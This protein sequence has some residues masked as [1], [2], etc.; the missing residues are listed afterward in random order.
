[1][2]TPKGPE[3][4]LRAVSN[5]DLI[6]NLTNQFHRPISKAS[7]SPPHKGELSRKLEERES[8]VSQLQR[9]KNSLS[10][11]VEELKKQLDEENK[12]SSPSPHLQIWQLPLQKFTVCLTAL[13]CLV[14]KV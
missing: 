7:V 12:V 13:H 1:M 4:S 3:L 10:Q 5:F 6:M 2:A 11:N 9:S 14:F 8:M